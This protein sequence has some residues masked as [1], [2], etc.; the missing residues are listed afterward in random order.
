MYYLFFAVYVITGND[1]NVE[2]VVTQ[3]AHCYEHLVITFGKRVLIK[4]ISCGDAAKGRAIVLC[5]KVGG[6]KVEVVAGSKQSVKAISIEGYIDIQV[7]AVASVE[8]VEGFTSHP[9]QLVMLVE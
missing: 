2:E 3:G 4:T 7:K 9:R 5:I 6:K 8:S 1:L